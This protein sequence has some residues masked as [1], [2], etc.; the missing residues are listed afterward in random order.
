MDTHDQE[1]EVARAAVQLR[2]DRFAL[3][4]AVLGLTTDVEI[5]AAAGYSRR[6]IARARAGQF[7]VVFVA[8]TI[9]VLQ[10]RAPELA[11][12][13]LSPDLDELFVVVDKAT[14]QRAA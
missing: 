10:Q 8:N 12:Y 5:A 3:M 11:K 7:G 14:A 9:H 6:T 2:A 4:F 1:E 13:G